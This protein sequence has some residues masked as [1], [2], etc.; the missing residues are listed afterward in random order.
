MNA[1]ALTFWLAMR[2]ELKN[3]NGKLEHENTAS[4]SGFPPFTRCAG[5]FGLANVLVRPRGDVVALFVQSANW[6]QYHASGRRF[7]ASTLT[8]QS[9]S[10][11]VKAS[12][13]STT[14][15]VLDGLSQTANETQ[16]G[17][18]W[19]GNAPSLGAA[20]VHNNTDALNGSPCA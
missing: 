17:T 19:S 13:E 10:T 9:T 1:S 20:R 16:M 6:N 18:L 4:L 12:P 5:V 15:P 3:P 14:R 2:Y 8:V 7:V 11:L